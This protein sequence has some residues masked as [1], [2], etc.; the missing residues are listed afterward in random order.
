[1]PMAGADI[2]GFSGEASEELCARWL[3]LGA[4]YP[5]SRSHSD[6][7]SPPQEPYRWPAVERAARR[8]LSTRY[9]LLPY[10]YTAFREAH[11]TGAPV[12]RP[13]WFNYPGDTATHKVD[14][15]FMVGGALLVT[16]ALD[17]GVDTVR[18]HFPGGTTWYDL[19][20]KSH[21]VD[22]R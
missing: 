2:C 15:Q 7:H 11:A 19:F 16:P 12:M 22:T 20:N 1:M 4:F 14:R 8:T 21:S 3:A 10:L 18:G 9:S 6:L 13:L 17:P 5:F